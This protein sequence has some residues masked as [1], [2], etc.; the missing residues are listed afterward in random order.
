MYTGKEYAFMTINKWAQDL[1]QVI[2]SNNIRLNES[3]KTIL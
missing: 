2:N 3:L 1:A